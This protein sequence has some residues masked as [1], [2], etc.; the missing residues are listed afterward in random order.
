MALR[1]GMGYDIHRLVGGRKLFLGGVEIP[2]SK[3]LL[4]HSDGDVLL[5]AVCDALFGACG[6]GDIGMHFPDTAAELKSIASVELLKRTL[7]IINK[8]KMCKILNIDTIVV[9]DEPKLSKYAPGIKSVISGALGI[10]ADIINIKAKTTEETKADAIS[11][12]AVV[13]VEIKTGES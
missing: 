13:L 7:A 12:Y 3:G 1:V 4:G 6:L 10:N 5:H 11:S 9:C 2:F 8:E